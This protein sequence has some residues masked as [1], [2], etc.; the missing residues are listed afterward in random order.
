MEKLHALTEVLRHQM[1]VKNVQKVASTISSFSTIVRILP[2]HARMARIYAFAST[3]QYKRMRRIPSCLSQ[4][5]RDLAQV[6]IGLQCCLPLMLR[7]LVPRSTSTRFL[8]YSDAALEKEKKEG[9]MGGVVIRVEVADRRF[10]PVLAWTCDISD[11]KFGI[12]ELESFAVSAT[13]LEAGDMMNGCATDHRIDNSGALFSLIS[14]TAA[15]PR[16]RAAAAWGATQLA[17]SDGLAYVQTKRN[18]ADLLTRG[19]IFRI[20]VLSL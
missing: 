18:I 10:E 6:T 2:F 15:N 12:E 14:G 9:S 7:A 4:L 16:T 5:F 20:H 11:C 1:S 8:V 3:K 19:Q 13:R 17:I